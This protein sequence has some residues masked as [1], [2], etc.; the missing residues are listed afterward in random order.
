MK[1]EE[2][3]DYIINLYN[4]ESSLLILGAPGIGKSTAANEAARELARLKNKE[5]INYDDTYADKILSK[6][7]RYFVLVDFRLTEVEPADLMGI[8]KEC[9]EGVCYKPFLWA[10]ALSKSEGILLLDEFTNVQ[11]LD[12]ISASYKLILD[13]K[14]GFTKFN[15]DVMVITAGNSPEES[16]VS[17]LL[18]TPL[19]DRFTIVNVEAPT[20]EAWTEWM[21]KNFDIWDRRILGY[22]KHFSDEFLKLPKEPETL[23]NFP[24]PRS[25]SKVATLLPQISNAYWKTIAEGRLGPDTGLKF[26]T[27]LNIQIPALEDFL[28]HPKEFENLNLDQK[29]LVAV[30]AG[31][32]L[33]KN[34]ENIEKI[35]HAVPL[36]KIMGGEFLVLS[37]ISS[38]QRK[39]EVAI[40]LVEQDKKLKDY[41]EQISILRME[42]E[43]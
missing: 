33:G 17:N 35:K 34:V 8:P 30:M 29:Y 43:K 9:N 37:V 21:D 6:P 42:F 39:R 28:A 27:F 5:F 26:F 4:K 23:E 24:S 13:H 7:D 15:K 20:I 25:W 16:S 11:R 38:G 3:K 40:K 19:I 18:P 31:N 14:A 41:L 10:L 22:L 36:L 1:I 2:L 12:V 32:H